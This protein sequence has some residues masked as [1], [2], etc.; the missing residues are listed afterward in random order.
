M[1]AHL[2]I[3]PVFTFLIAT[4]LSVWG[5]KPRLATFFL[6][7]IVQARN[8]KCLLFINSVQV[9]R[10]KGYVKLLPHKDYTTECVQD[11]TYL[12][13]FFGSF[14]LSSSPSPVPKLASSLKS[15]KTKQFCVLSIAFRALRPE[16]KLK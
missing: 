12:S 8:M 6:A 5:I 10:R 13:F 16:M 4:T 7:R 15:I 14:S 1:P 2:A 11:L 9:Q 3:Q